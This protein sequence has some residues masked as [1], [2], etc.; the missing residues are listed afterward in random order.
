MGHNGSMSVG[1]YGLNRYGLDAYGGVAPVSILEAYPLGPRSIYVRFNVEPMT[2]S[3]ITVGDC[4]NI[5]T[6]DLTRGDTGARIEV[7]GAVRLKLPEER[8]LFLLSPIGPSSVVHTL[9]AVRLRS[10]GG[11]PSAPP[12]RVTFRGVDVDRPALGPASRRP[13]VVDL[14]NDNFFGQGQAIQPVDGAS[15]AVQSGASGLRK[16]ILR[17]LTTRPGEHP[18]D[19]LFGCDLRLG[20]LVLDP[21]AQRRNIE[22]QVRRDPEV[23]AASVSVEVLDEGVAYITVRAQLIGGQTATETFAVDGDGVRLG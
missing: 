7:I 10:A 2:A 11:L 5:R 12:D 4:Q 16:R 13:L 19:P 14:R 21:A 8:R 17:I 15:Y 18:A 3:P 6:W 1:I 23:A 22:E 20:E 9:S